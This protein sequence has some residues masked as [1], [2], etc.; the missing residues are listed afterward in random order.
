MRFAMTVRTERNRVS[1]NIA[2]AVCE[3]T[4]M[5]DLQEGPAVLLLEWCTLSAQ[6]AATV[7][8]LE[9]PAL[10]LRVAAH[11]SDLPL[12]ARGFFNTFWGVAERLEG[13][14]LVLELVPVEHLAP[15][16]AEQPGHAPANSPTVI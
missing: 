11:D 15:G 13:I 14:G 3:P 7:G 1:G 12:D 6:L 2:T 16:I 8:A 5:V 4:N 9:N 10:D